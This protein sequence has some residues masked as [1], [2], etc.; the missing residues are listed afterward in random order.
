MRSRVLAR[1]CRLILLVYAVLDNCGLELLSDLALADL[2]LH[3]KEGSV[4]VSSSYT[5]VRGNK[6]TPTVRE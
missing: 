6:R 4:A 3:D 2:L 1:I 5:D